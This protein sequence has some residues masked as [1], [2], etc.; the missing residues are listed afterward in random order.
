LDSILRKTDYEE[1]ENQNFAFEMFPVYFLFCF[2]LFCYGESLLSSG[3]DTQGVMTNMMP[4]FGGFPL[5][6]NPMAYDMD[7]DSTIVDC[8]E[9]IK[10]SEGLRLF[11]A[12]AAA[13]SQQ[14]QES[15]CSEYSQQETNT[16]WG[17]DVGEPKGNGFE[18][19]AS[20]TGRL[21]T[22]SLSL[23]AEVIRRGISGEGEAVL[24]GEETGEVGEVWIAIYKGRGFGTLMRKQKFTAGATLDCCNTRQCTLHDY[25]F[26][27]P[28]DVI[29]SE[30]Y[31]V[32][33]SLVDVEDSNR[34][35]HGGYDF[36]IHAN[37]EDSKR[38]V[39]YA[40]GNRMEL[41]HGKRSSA[42]FGTS[43]CSPAQVCSQE[44]L[45]KAKKWDELFGFLSSL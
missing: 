44:T 41:I 35:V 10:C 26:S 25:T 9:D 5:G 29:E 28:I 15:E 3:S 20:K 23:A 42:Y 19:T 7:P 1:R 17:L 21:H 6:F 27:N 18:F 45:E 8:V 30:T 33:F 14:Q 38:N 32:G 36:Y 24:M 4:M 40:D 12:R 39:W 13:Q 37:I 16:C 2:V 34:N 11:Q 31:T 22:L 43:I